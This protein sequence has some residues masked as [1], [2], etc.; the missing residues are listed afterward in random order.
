MIVE[1]GNI[2]LT[3]I[4]IMMEHLSSSFAMMLVFALMRREKA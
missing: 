1:K 4:I 2:N 3:L